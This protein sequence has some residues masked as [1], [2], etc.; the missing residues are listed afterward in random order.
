MLMHKWKHLISN[1]SHLLIIISTVISSTKSNV[2]H[3]KSEPSNG[4]KIVIISMRAT[5]GHKSVSDALEAEFKRIGAKCIVLYVDDF[6]R[7]MIASPLIVEKIYSHSKFMNSNYAVLVEQV[8][9]NIVYQKVHNFIAYDIFQEIYKSNINASVVLKKIHSENPSAIICVVGI[10]AQLTNKIADYFC[11][12]DQSIVPMFVIPTDLSADLVS[13]FV[14]ASENNYALHYL[15]CGPGLY[16][17]ALKY[18][19]NTNV[20]IHNINGL[21]IRK[22]DNISKSDARTKLGISPDKEV[23]LICAGSIGTQWMVSLLEYFIDH[24]LSQNR[25]YIFIFGKSENLARQAQCICNDRHIPRDKIKVIG[26]ERD[27]L[28]YMKAADV[29]VGKAGPT[30]LSE[31]VQCQT[32]AVLINS[33]AHEQPTIHHFITSQHTGVIAEF[34][35]RSILDKINHVIQNHSDYMNSLR[36]YIPNIEYVRQEEQRLEITH[37]NPYDTRSIFDKYK[38]NT[39]TQDAV[40]YVMYVLRNNVSTAE[41]I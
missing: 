5:G 16:H 27:I 12:H 19:A 6:I 18:Y 37:S 22:I 23:V 13:W 36:L 26:F 30:V 21:P 35:Q 8:S 39:G 31:L 7:Y 14:K 32:P 38:D 40:R 2:E 3:S 33:Q 20:A 11:N 9:N 41:H 29:C 1:A 25:Q 10:A 17:E 28:K 34:T 24:D 15:T 4:Q